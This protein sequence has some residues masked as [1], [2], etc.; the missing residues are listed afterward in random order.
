MKPSRH[1]SRLVAIT[2][3]TLSLGTGLQAQQQSED[4]ATG[5]VV[6]VDPSASSITIRHAPI[7]KLH[8]KAMTMMFHAQDPAILDDVKAGDRVR[9]DAEKV[10]GQYTVTRIEKRR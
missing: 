8:M 4:L 6:K 2:L 1:A 5:R 10:D 9:F 3:I 7:K